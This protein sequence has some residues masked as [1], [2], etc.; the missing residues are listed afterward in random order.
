MEKLPAPIGYYGKPQWLMYYEAEI[1]AKQWA[2]LAARITEIQIK[3][4]L[5]NVT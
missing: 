5:N 2:E 3:M 4:R 1:R